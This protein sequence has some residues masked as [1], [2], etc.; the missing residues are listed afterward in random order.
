MKSIAFWY[1]TGSTYSYL[2]IVRLPGVEVASGIAFNWHPFN[3]RHVTIE[4]NNIPF[5]NKPVKSFYMWRDIERRAGLYG[6]SPKIPAP[7]PLPGLVLANQ[8]AVLGAEEGWC[9]A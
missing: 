1:S 5:H 9:A 8:V 7:Y 2:T 6:L 3:V 4:R